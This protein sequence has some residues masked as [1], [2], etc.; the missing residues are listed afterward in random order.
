MSTLTDTLLNLLFPRRCPL[1]GSLT[2]ESGTPQL[3]PQCREK[4]TRDLLALCPVCR[5]TAG[6]CQCFPDAVREAGDAIGGVPMRSLGF[7]RPET[8]PISASLIYVLKQQPDDTA[9]RILARMLSM[10]AVRHFTRSGENIREWTIC[11][12]PRSEPNRLRYGF[13][14]GQRL[15]RLM[16]KSCGAGYRP[17]FGRR[18]GDTQKSLS[19]ADRRE[20][21]DTSLYLRD[22]NVS[23]G[24]FII[25]DDIITTGATVARCAALLKEAGA[26][27]VF[28]MSVLRTPYKKTYTKK[29]EPL[30]FAM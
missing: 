15:A 17:V 10:E 21:T 7:Y 16:S 8:E 2:E 28:I 5:R 30:W 13:D 1:C 25:V 3:C 6:D 12:P 4:L 23:G 27:S 11:Y 14:H 9:A 19:A 29:D 22:K 20:N 24:K 18:G 26:R